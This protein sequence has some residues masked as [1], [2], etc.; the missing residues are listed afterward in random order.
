MKLA[1]KTFNFSSLP[2]EIE[3]K[4]LS[5]IKELPKLLGSPHKVSFYQL[6]WI[7]SGNATFRI[8]F[9]DIKLSENDVLVISPGQVCEFDVHSDYKGKMILFTDTFFSISDTD[10]NF[11][12]TS[13]ILSLTNKNHPLSI[14]PDMMGSLVA[15]LTEELTSP[16]D[17]F[18]TEISQSFL[19]IILLEAER[20]L[21]AI[22]PTTLS[23]L[24]SR[25]FN[26]VEMHFMEEKRVDFYIDL[27]AVNEKLLT[28]E[29]KKLLDET[30]KV[31]IDKRVILEAK[32]LLVY[33]NLSVK[34][35]GFSLGFDEP[36]NFNK[37]FKKH[38][39]TTPID[40]RNSI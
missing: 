37:Y 36:T 17:R 4:D 23:S 38:T 27:L 30:P 14:C 16:V 24:G 9:R 18:Q 15:L 5:F 2:V 39:E 26:A 22:A 11:L 6:A 33:S 19:R 21:N 29:I 32:R 25:F 1:I 20:Q 12:H 34:E 35:I 13:Q 10:T 7:S 28:K 31:Y 3:V 40:F 8:D